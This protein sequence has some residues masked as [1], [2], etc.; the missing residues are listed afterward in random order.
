MKKGI[1][2][3][4]HSLNKITSLKGVSYYWKTDEYPDKNFEDSKQIGLIAQ[5]VETIIP[6]IV[7]TDDEGYKSI[8]YNKL[9]PVLIEAV[10][11]LK[12]KNDCLQQQINSQQK[13]IDELKAFVNQLINNT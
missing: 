5:E 12:T 7:Q 13:E 10:K 3:L 9:T 2:P 8:R 1:A 11:E 4:T 6:E